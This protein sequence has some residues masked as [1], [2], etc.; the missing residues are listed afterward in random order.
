VS[1]QAMVNKRLANATVIAC[2]HGPWHVPVVISHSA[3]NLS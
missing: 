2:A 1:S 3:S